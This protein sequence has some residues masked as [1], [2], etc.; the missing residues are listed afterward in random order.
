MNLICE[1]ILRSTLEHDILY[2]TWIGIQ[3]E[4]S[5]EANYGLITNVVKT[6]MV[7]KHKNIF[8]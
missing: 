6:P 5:L 1:D 3:F 8:L 4:H 2:M 7:E